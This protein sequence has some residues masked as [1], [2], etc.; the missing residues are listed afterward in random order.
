MRGERRHDSELVLK[1]PERMRGHRLRC[2]PVGREAQPILRLFAS[3]KWPLRVSSTTGRGSKSVCKQLLSAKRFISIW[4]LAFVLPDRFR[5]SVSD[6]PSV[7]T[8]SRNHPSASILVSGE[9]VG[10]PLG[11]WG[12][13]RARLARSAITSPSCPQI[14]SHR[15][16]RGWTSVV[17][18]RSAAIGHWS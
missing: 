2:R 16:V 1:N 3:E 15:A 18:G 8:I 9:W 12:R 5:R 6:R 14:R 17:C 13:P 7:A 4:S 11:V 10:M